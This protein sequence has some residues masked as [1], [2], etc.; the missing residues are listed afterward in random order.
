MTTPARDE[1]LDEVVREFLA[2]TREILVRLEE[3]LV[4]LERSPNNPELLAGIFRGFHT[5]KGNSSFLGYTRVEETAHAAEALLAAFRDGRRRPA[6]EAVSALLQAVD[7]VTRLVAPIGS[8]GAE[9]A[10]EVAPLVRRLSEF[11][12]AVSAPEA[13]AARAPAAAEPAARPAADATVRVDVGLLDRLMNL[14]GE[15]VLARNQLLQHLPASGDSAG[16]RAAHRVN[17]I[18]SRLQEGILKTRMQPVGNLLHRFS[19][20]VRDLAVTCGKRARLETS[21]EDTELDRAI[22]EAIS[23]PLTH[24]L[25]NAVDHGIETPEARARAGKPEEGLIR[26]HAYHES[27]QVVLEV[28]DDG[29]GVDVSKVRDRAVRLGH[30]TAQAAEQMPEPELLALI[31]A[32][33]LS[34]S[35]QVTHVSGRGVGMD[36]VKSNIERV[37]GAIELVNAPGRGLVVRIR[38]PLTLAILPALIIS[39]GGE[40]FAL[41]QGC[42]LELIRPGET[43]T[44]RGIERIHDAPVYRLRGKLLPL[45]YLSRFLGTG[46]DTPVSP[47]VVVLQGADQAFGLVVDAVHD[48]EEIV[49]KSLSRRLRELDLYAG[50]AILGDGKIALILDVAGL[51]RRAKLKLDAAAVEL[52]SASAARPATG[53]ACRRLLLL[54]SGD[55]GRLAVD[56]AGVARLEHFRPDKIE[57][58]AGREMVQYRGEIIPLL[59]ISEALP[60]RRKQPRS[61]AAPDGADGVPVVIYRQAD[62]HVG[63]VVDSVLDIVEEALHSER[64]ATRT[65]VLTCAVVRD[66]VTEI[67]DMDHLF[68]QAVA[69]GGAR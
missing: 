26:I 55:G 52:N 65:G 16:S 66:R 3:G 54:G 4:T 37:G 41:P 35:E 36:V 38:I 46:S 47:T 6:P 33:G 45:I 25:R 58:V 42:L 23:E 28:A 43:G 27:G 10:V 30:V 68:R 8:G 11:S 21:G 60:E 7:A 50:A 49:V 12:G 18:T 9:A 19:R 67:L 44:Q 22:L 14:V 40:K 2:E 31:F 20:V 69:A 5:I 53:P 63:L 48:T 24:L 29:A 61:A 62:R 51:A 57:S 34:T 56:L 64:P 39:A 15:L 17:L 32:R 1:G 59:R 13:A